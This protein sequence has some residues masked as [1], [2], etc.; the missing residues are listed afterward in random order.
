MFEVNLIRTEAID[1]LNHLDEWAALQRVP[2]PALHQKADPCYIKPE[3][4]G[5]ALVIGAWNYPLQLSIL[6]IVGAITAGET[7]PHVK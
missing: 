6:P 3:P 2:T 7:S 4:Y 5:V 1:H